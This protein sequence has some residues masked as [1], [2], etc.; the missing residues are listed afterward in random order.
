MKQLINGIIKSKKF[1]YAMASILVPLASQKL[2]VDEASAQTI[3]YSFV[4]LILGQ[5]MADWG[6]HAK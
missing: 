5:G 6:K 1:W 3:F 2:G 4:A